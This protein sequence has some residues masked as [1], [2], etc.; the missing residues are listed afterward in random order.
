MVVIVLVRDATEAATPELSAS[1]KTLTAVA[2]PETVA[3][4]CDGEA[5]G[6]VKCRTPDVAK[7]RT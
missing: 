6:V 3:V 7:H 4:G 5:T 2:A 1:R